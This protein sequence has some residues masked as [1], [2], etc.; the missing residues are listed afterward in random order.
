M[1]AALGDVGEGRHRYVVFLTDGYVGN[2]RQIFGSAERL[3]A[4]QAR[5]GRK[6]RVFG[7]GIGSSVNR[8]LIDGLARAGA[9][10]A[11]YVGVDENP[12]RAVDRFYRGI[13]HPVLTDVT[14]DWGDLAVE[15]VEPAVLPDLL[16]TAP[17][18]VMAKYS[19]P[20]SGTVTIRG[21]LDGK[22]LALPVRVELP[23]PPGKVGQWTEQVDPR[24]AS[25]LPSLWARARIETLSRRLWQGHDSEAVEQITELGLAY[26]LVTA[27]TSFVA[28][29]RSRVVGNGDPATVVQPVEAPAGV[30]PSM[31]APAQA[32][33]GNKMAASSYGRGGLGTRGGG[34]GGGGQA[35]GFG[36]LGVG[37]GTGGGGLGEGTI[38]TIGRGSSGQG[39]GRGAVRLKQK[40][41]R[42]PKIVPGKPVV[43]GSLDRDI[44]RRVI[45]R[46]RKQ[47]RY[48]YEK[49]LQ[50]APTME[51]RVQLKLVI[52]PDGSVLSAAIADTTLEN[53]VVEQCIA[54]KAKRWRFPA[55]KGG[56][57]V[58]VTYPFLFKPE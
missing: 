21:K 40:K 20:G 42:R 26:R 38:G 8:H 1:G 49:E 5:A 51:G 31:A 19:A 2:E 56:G 35:G 18:V 24:K 27:Y 39:Y 34:V 11:M 50:K 10:T 41:V 15:S 52:G 9:G 58:V 57:R 33:M 14:I 29:D 44:I 7:M 13:D 55:V 48:C 46:H 30:D 16:A 3:V 17:L 23:A 25:A 22:D 45:R 53:A 43:M 4:A 37:T 32:L 47:V 54:L 28:V 12:D 6:A 36:G